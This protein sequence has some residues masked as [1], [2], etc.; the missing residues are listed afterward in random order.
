MLWTLRSKTSVISSITHKTTQDR[1][2]VANA[3]TA[4]LEKELKMTASE[5]SACISL[6][7]VGYIVFE[8]PACLFLKKVTPNIQLGTAL[9]FWGTFTTL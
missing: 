5:L 4:G 1:G 3:Y 6:F 7:Y 2:D 9:I 8:L